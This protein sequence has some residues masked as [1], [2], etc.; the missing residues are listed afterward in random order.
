MGN[1]A[2]YRVPGTWESFVPP[3]PRDDLP[4]DYGGCAACGGD[5]FVG[6]K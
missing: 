4:L 2:L 6:P 3:P 5:V 1:G